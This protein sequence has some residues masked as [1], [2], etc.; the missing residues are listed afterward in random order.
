MSAIFLD[1]FVLLTL[2]VL[3]FYQTFLAHPIIKPEHAA[4]YTQPTWTRCI[5]S[6]SFSDLQT[7][8]FQTLWQWWVSGLITVRVSQTL[9]N[10]KPVLLVGFVWFIAFYLLVTLFNSLSRDL[11]QRRCLVRSRGSR[12]IHSGGRKQHQSRTLRA[13]LDTWGNTDL[14]L[15]CWGTD[16]HR[17]NRQTQMDRQTDKRQTDWFIFFFYYQIVSMMIFSILL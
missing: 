15:I 10:W 16:T 8:F 9:C 11:P 2:L 13:E 17:I 4:D 5:F 12:C 6:L 3:L 7:T 1:Y 14:L